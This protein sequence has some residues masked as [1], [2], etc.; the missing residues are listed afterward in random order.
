MAASRN[1]I[2]LCLRQMFVRNMSASDADQAATRFVDLYFSEGSVD[3]SDSNIS[4]LNMSSAGNCNAVTVNATTAVN[5]AV[6]RGTTSVNTAIV[7]ATT[8]VRTVDV[9]TT[10]CNATTGN[11]T[12][13]AA[14][15]IDATGGNIAYWKPSSTILAASSDNSSV[16]NLSMLWVNTATGNIVLGGLNHGKAQ[17]VL[18]VAIAADFTNTVTLEHAE[19]S[20]EQKLYLQ[21]GGDEAKK[22]GGWTLVCNGTAWFAVGGSTD[23]A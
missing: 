7:N 13:V 17:Q 10:N 5:T 21:S 1:D 9:V 2:L 16:L 12:T 11:I 23:L 19:G 4:T 6:V 14:T 18:H 22:S 15:N 3:L 20:G 8:S